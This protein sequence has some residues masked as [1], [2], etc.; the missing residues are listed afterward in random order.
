MAIAT[1][2]IP[3][4]KNADNVLLIGGT[5]VTLDTLVGAFHA[6]ATAEEIALRYPSL[7]LADV[8]SCVSYYLQNQAE[9]EDYLQQRQQQAAEIR[10][11]NEAHFASDGIRTRLLERVGR[12][13]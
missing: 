12:R 3:L 2:S 8:Y 10:Q 9:V 1:L 13:D 7:K 5:R 11:Q 4:E 6:G